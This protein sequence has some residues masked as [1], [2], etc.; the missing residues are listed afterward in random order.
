MIASSA[1]PRVSALCLQRRYLSLGDIAADVACYIFERR[2]I[3]GV[4]FAIASVGLSLLAIVS[5]DHPPDITT[6]RTLADVRRLLPP[7]PGGAQ[8]IGYLASRCPL[9]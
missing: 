7:C 6:L 5:S 8:A 3:I 4:V 1:G 2:R 9:P